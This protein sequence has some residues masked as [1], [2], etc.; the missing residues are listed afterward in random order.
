MEYP[1]TQYAG[2]CICHLQHRALQKHV[3]NTSHTWVSPRI[4]FSCLAEQFDVLLISFLLG[5]QTTLDVQY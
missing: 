2:R 5:N 1:L 3:L 4:L